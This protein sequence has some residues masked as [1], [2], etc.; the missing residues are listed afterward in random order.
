M[1][2][3]KAQGSIEYLLIIGATILVVAVVIIALSGILKETLTQTD[4]NDYNDSLSDLR[5][6]KK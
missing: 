5:N 1:I 2:E 6:T 4:G 3:E